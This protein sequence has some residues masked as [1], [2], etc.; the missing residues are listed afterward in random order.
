MCGCATTTPGSSS[1]VRSS[2]PFA[3]VA[4]ERVPIVARSPDPA[5]SAPHISARDLGMSGDDE[6]NVTVRSGTGRDEPVKIRITE[7]GRIGVVAPPPGSFT[8][9]P[10][11][12]VPVFQNALDRVTDA[13][14]DRLRG[15]S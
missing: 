10:F 6:I 11:L 15:S 3:Q 12:D 5:Q 7:D 8:M 9:D 13:A 14:L 2:F 1:I 4:E